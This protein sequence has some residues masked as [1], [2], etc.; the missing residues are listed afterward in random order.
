MKKNNKAWRLRVI[1]I[2]I[3][4]HTGQELY[5]HHLKMQHRKKDEKYGR[6]C[7]YHHLCENHAIEHN[8]SVKQFIKKTTLARF[9]NH[10][11]CFS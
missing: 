3:P 7:V 5:H 11:R 4:C 1:V 6:Y 8:L 2:K 9:N 10:Q